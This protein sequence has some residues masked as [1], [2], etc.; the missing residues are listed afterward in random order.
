MS[1][2]KLDRETTLYR[3]WGAPEDQSGKPVLLYVGI[4]HHAIVRLSQHKSRGHWYR[5][6]VGLT[7]EHFE[8]RK[9]ALLAEKKAIQNEKPIY[10]VQMNREGGGLSQRLIER[11]KNRRYLIGKDLELSHDAVLSIMPAS[12]THEA[13]AYYSGTGSGCLDFGN[14]SG[15]TGACYYGSAGGWV[16]HSRKAS[17]GFKGNITFL[18]NK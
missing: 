4:S 9:K 1:G 12:T 11:R 13:N 6:C 5:E 8:T 3:A 18:E 15:N 2:E 10:N 16:D 7:L 14:M 17:V